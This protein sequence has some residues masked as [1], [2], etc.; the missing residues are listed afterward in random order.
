MQCWPCKQLEGTSEGKSL[1][2]GYE[3]GLSSKLMSHAPMD[4]L[5]GTKYGVFNLLQ[6]AAI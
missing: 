6:I 3:P 2:L 1:W 5:E 4:T